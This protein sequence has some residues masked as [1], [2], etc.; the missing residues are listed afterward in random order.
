[1]LPFIEQ[2]L[3]SISETTSKWIV[4]R[5]P[6][7]DPIWLQTHHYS[8]SELFHILKNTPSFRRALQKHPCFRT[9]V[10]TCFSEQFRSVDFSTHLQGVEKTGEEGISPETKGY[11]DGQVQK[12]I[13]HARNEALVASGI[14]GALLVGAIT[15]VAGCMGA[16]VPL[17]LWAADKHHIAVRQEMLRLNAAN[18]H[19]IEQRLPVKGMRITRSNIKPPVLKALPP[20]KHRE[21]VLE[22]ETKLNQLQESVEALTN[23]V[24][25]EYLRS[26]A[27]GNS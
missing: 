13:R 19:L 4:F 12:E 27:Q 16:M 18:Q 17:F 26:Q 25:Q 14:V 24:N 3:L 11:V 15:I 10:E 2:H 23:E 6:D 22:M 1:M 7:D 9:V 21:T 8:K 20:K 5:T